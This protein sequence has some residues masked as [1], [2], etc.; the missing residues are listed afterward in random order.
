MTVYDRDVERIAD[1]LEA[2]AQELKAL[3]ELAERVASNVPA[4]RPAPPRRRA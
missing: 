4:P 1:A 2:I 3:R